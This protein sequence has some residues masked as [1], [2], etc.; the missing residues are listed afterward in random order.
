MWESILILAL[1]QKEIDSHLRALGSVKL[2]IPSP[3]RGEGIQSFTG[4]YAPARE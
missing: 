4:P 2:Y 1:C 3:T